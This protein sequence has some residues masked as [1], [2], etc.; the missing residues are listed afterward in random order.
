M[1]FITNRRL[2]EGRRSSAGRSISF[3]LTDSEP[4]ASLY[5]CQRRGSGLYEE[6][7]AAPFLGRL[8]RSPRQQILLVT[9]GFNCQ[10]EKDVFPRALELQGLCDQLA[11]G[12]VEVVPLV[13]PCDDDFGV[14]LDYWDDQ[15]SAEVSGHAFARLI[16]KFIDWRDRLATEE[17]CLKH[18]NILAHSMGNRVLRAA[19]ARWSR[20]YGSVPAIFRSIFMVAA[21]VANECLEPGHDGAMIPQA[22]RNLVV[23]HAADDF[24]LRSSKVANLRNKVVTRRLGHTGPERL[25]RVPANVSAVDCDA[26]NSAYDRL[27]HTYFL[28]D[29]QGRPG[30]V[31]RHIVETMRTGR[32]G[33]RRQ[34]LGESLV[35][36]N[37]DLAGARVA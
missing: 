31:L 29:G 10:P 6:L 24:A 2:N 32:P 1:L 22:A 11:P 14:M 15:A 17:I 30:T 20:D 26:F 3:D 27:G 36:A 13:W 8:R 5:F 28:G 35:A 25:D 23:Y 21:D 4:G 34:V 16:G 33:T 18:I 37:D 7:L 12:L 19:L 9:H